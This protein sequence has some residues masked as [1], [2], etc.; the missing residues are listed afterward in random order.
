VI[1]LGEEVDS[2]RSPDGTLKENDKFESEKQTSRPSAPD[3]PFEFGSGPGAHRG[4]T[5]DW[6]PNV[7]GRR[8]P[9]L[10][11][12][13]EEELDWTAQDRLGLRVA[14]HVGCGSSQSSQSGY[15]LLISYAR[16]H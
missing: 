11:L 10:H 6:K 4:S 5:T 3:Q 8:R 7:T 12:P 14:L 13:L 2:R 15:S 1:G 16:S 9:S